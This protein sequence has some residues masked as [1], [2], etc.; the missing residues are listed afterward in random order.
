MFLFLAKFS[1]GIGST[2]EQ[3]RQQDVS[4]LYFC[5]QNG[6]LPVV[7]FYFGLFLTAAFLLFVGVLTQVVI[8]GCNKHNK[9]ARSSKLIESM[10]IL[11][12]ASH[13][14]FVPCSLLSVGNVLLCGV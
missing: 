6:H 7:S 8:R 5:Q 3:D 14:K 11:R 12:T 4:R 2:Q 1:L 9:A 13:L 10:V